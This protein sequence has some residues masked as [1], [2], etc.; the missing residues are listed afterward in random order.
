M[1]VAISNASGETQKKWLKFLIERVGHNNLPKLL[2]YYISIGWISQKAADT[3]LDMALIEPRYKGESWTLSAHEQRISRLFIEK[4]K[5]RDIDESLLD[6]P[7]P[8]KAVPD[9][10]RKISI[11][12]PEHLHPEEKK[13]MEFN[14]HRREVIIKNL[15]MELDEKYSEIKKLN[16][17]IRELETDL[18]D[19]RNVRMLDKIYLDLM[20]QNLRLKKAQKSGKAVK[21]K[22]KS[23]KK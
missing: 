15:E 7:F 2:D 23:S 13:K 20:N 3:L 12:P 5:G 14:I 16:E 19:M 6:V 11:K 18:L 4:L 1:L 9:I 8:G 21:L 10:E 22:K 17:R